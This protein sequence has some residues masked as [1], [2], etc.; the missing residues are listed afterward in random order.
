M[1]QGEA[2]KWGIIL[3]CTL[4]Y[5]NMASNAVVRLGVEVLTLALRE[6]LRKILL[7]MNKKRKKRCF[8]ARPWILRR[9]QLGASET[10]QKELALEDTESYRN[11]LRV[12]EEKYGAIN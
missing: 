5:K 9:N 4:S 8:W 1:R 6:E 12:P 10:L 7:D 2:V 11:H 3:K